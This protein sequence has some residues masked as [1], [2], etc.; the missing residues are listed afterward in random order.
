MNIFENVIKQLQDRGLKVTDNQV[1]EKANEVIKLRGISQYF[2][3]IDS[4]QL[5]TKID[6]IQGYFLYGK[7]YAYFMVDTAYNH[8]YGMK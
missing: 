5:D 2:N 8:K 4:I 7:L 6:E 3:G 1:I